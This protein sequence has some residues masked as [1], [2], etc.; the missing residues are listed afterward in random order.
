MW[1]TGEKVGRGKIKDALE[2]VGGNKRG[3][4]QCKLEKKG[5]KNHRVRR[6]EN[7]NGSGTRFGDVGGGGGTIFLQIYKKE[8]AAG[9]N[10]L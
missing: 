3:A 7:L 10:L 9:G 1:T 4:K 5:S 6:G 2:A 8:N